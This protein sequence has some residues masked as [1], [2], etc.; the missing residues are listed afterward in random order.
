MVK[1]ELSLTNFNGSVRYDS[2]DRADEANFK[3]QLTVVE[4]WVLK[5]DLL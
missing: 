4:K 5:E 3:F 2:D 1:L